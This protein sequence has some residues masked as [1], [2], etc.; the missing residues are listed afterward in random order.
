M[1]G[2]GVLC[3]LNGEWAH[4]IYMVYFRIE[5]YDLL[6]GSFNKI[7][8]G[9]QL[10]QFKT[11]WLCPTLGCFHRLGAR[12]SKQKQTYFFSQKCK[13]SLVCR[14]SWANAMNLSWVDPRKEHVAHFH[15][16]VRKGRPGMWTCQKRILLW[17]ITWI[18]FHSFS[19][20]AG[21]SQRTSVLTFWLVGAPFLC[22][23]GFARACSIFPKS[24]FDN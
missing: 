9:T 1:F 7:W 5:M 2:L 15:R 20:M 21:F 22:A 18:L 23:I 17:N 10:A 11:G 8:F 6:T 16:F 3:V 24:L 13:G 12:Q 19:C 4:I 14:D